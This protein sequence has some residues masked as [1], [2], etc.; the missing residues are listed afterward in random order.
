MRQY[1]C[2]QSQIYI[3]Y[4]I[5]I[6]LK[7]FTKLFVVFFKHKKTEPSIQFVRTVRKLDVI[8]TPHLDFISKSLS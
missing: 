6:Y 2:I 1:N 7:I 4:F 3:T 8:E 5:I